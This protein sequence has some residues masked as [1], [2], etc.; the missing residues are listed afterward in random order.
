[1]LLKNYLRLTPYNFFSSL[2]KS[3]DILSLRKLEN[4]IQ[5]LSLFFLQ[6]FEIVFIK[7]YHDHYNI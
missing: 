6:K 3:L 5:N 7:K 4:A 1:M 2:K